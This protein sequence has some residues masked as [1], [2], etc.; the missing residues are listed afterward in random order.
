MEKLRGKRR[1]KKM[2]GE[3]R[4]KYHWIK[5]SVSRTA[6]ERRHKNGDNAKDEPEPQKE[7][8]R[9]LELVDF[10]RE[11]LFAEQQPFGVEAQERVNER[12]ENERERQADIRQHDRRR[13]HSEEHHV[14]DGAVNG[15]LELDR[16]VQV[17]AVVQ[18]VRE[19]GDF[20]EVG[21]EELHDGE[22]DWQ[23]PETHVQR[24][25]SQ[26]CAEVALEEALHERVV[27]DSEHGIDA[28]AEPDSL[29]ESRPEPLVFL[30]V[31]DELPDL[32]AGE[33]PYVG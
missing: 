28:G 1:D 10:I 2:K 17:R 11:R 8:P 20:P 31:L 23:R 30:D 26:A 3:K 9:A 22:V 18:R 19:L 25:P 15:V 7:R 24:K 13:R 14:E 27:D 21:A 4:G 32:Q 5:D 33:Q 29:G 6:Q 16:L 12:R